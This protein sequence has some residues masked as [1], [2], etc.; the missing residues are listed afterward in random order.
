MHD[1][2]KYKLTCTFTGCYFNHLEPKHDL[3]HP[4]CQEHVGTHRSCLLFGI[5]DSDLCFTQLAMK[6][7]DLG[8]MLLGIFCRS[9]AG[10]F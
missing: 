6:A 7:R 10:T 9:R 2:G 3:K 5:S 8:L 1:L 4:R